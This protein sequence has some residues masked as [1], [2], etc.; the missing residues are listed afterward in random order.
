[1]ILNQARFRHDREPQFGVF[2]ERRLPLQPTDRFGMAMTMPA[3]TP[4]VYH[5]LQLNRQPFDDR[6]LP[7]PTYPR[8]DACEAWR[9]GWLVS[10]N[11]PPALPA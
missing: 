7:H 6:S 1:V 8:M 9:F 4:M 3:V 2:S 10:G 11:D 5:A